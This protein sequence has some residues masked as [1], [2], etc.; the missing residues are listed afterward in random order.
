M[1]SVA[2]WM[3]CRM[4]AGLLAGVLAI[5]LFCSVAVAA[6]PGVLIITPSPT[7]KPG[8]V[9]K[10]QGTIIF[11]MP[12]SFPQPAYGTPMKIGVDSQFFGWVTETQTIQAVGM[13]SITINFTKTFTVPANLKAGSVLNF[14][15]AWQYQQEGTT[16]Y[17]YNL[18]ETS[19]KVSALITPKPGIEKKVEKIEKVSPK[20]LQ[21]AK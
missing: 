18:A 14:W 17:T 21:K 12:A 10:F 3:K 8:G 5:F 19:V 1:E 13:G 4:A 15:L 9:L 16:L 6:D 7:V 2:C 20:E 11:P